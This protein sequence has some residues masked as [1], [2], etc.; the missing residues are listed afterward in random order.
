MGK[1]GGCKSTNIESSKPSEPSAA[2][3]VR[4]KMIGVSKVSPRYERTQC[5]QNKK[6]QDTRIRQ[7]TGFYLCFLK[8]WIDFEFAQAARNHAIKNPKINGN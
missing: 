5:G 1:M 7:P 3:E 8:I 4:T 2:R 6:R